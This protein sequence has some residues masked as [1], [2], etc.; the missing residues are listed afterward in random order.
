MFGRR[1]ERCFESQRALSQDPK[2]PF[3]QTTS[4]ESGRAELDAPR[5]APV[6]PPHVTCRSGVGEVEVS[7]EAPL[8]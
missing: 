2:I 7:C 6:R 5:P 3:F 8:L 4:H 1:W